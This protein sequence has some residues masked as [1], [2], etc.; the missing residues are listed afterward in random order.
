MRQHWP[1]ASIKL[2]FQTETIN[3]FYDQLKSFLMAMKWR[4]KTI[5]NDIELFNSIILSIN[6]YEN[7][8]PT[9]QLKVKRIMRNLMESKR[10]RNYA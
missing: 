10:K 8:E 7:M 2:S 5:F 9:T 6:L 4:R 3:Q 1:Y